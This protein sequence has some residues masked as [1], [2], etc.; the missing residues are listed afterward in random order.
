MATDVGFGD[1]DWGRGNLAVAVIEVLRESQTSYCTTL[2][3]PMDWVIP[4][5]AVGVAAGMHSAYVEAVIC[6]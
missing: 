1:G 2:S 5:A 6:H 3:S 4:V